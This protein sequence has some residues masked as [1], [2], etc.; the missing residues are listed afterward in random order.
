MFVKKT[1]LLIWLFIVCVS[2]FIFFVNKHHYLQ[3]YDQQYWQERYDQSQWQLPLSK[4]IIGDDGLYLFVG[5]RLIHK[6]DP[7][8]LNPETPPLGKYLIG[9]STV[10]FNNGAI[11]SLFIYFLVLATFYWLINNIWAKKTKYRWRNLL[12][13]I[14]L[15]AFDPLIVQQASQTA[16]D[17]PQLLLLLTYLGLLVR[18]EKKRPKV[19]LFIT[20]AL[21]GIVLG[22]FSATKLP[23]ISP[24]LVLT[25]LVYLYKI[26][27]LPYFVNFILFALTAYLISYLGYFLS[28]HTLLDWL[29][30]QKWVLNFY[31]TSQVGTNFGSAFTFFISG[32]YRSLFETNWLTAETWTA[33]WPIIFLVCS[34]F[35]IKNRRQLSLM[36]GANKIIVIFAYVI[37]L[38]FC[39]LPFF[40]RYLTLVIPFFYLILADLLLSNAKQKLVTPILIFLL[41]LNAYSS[42]KIL[43][44]TPKSTFEQIAYEWENA[45]FADL[46]E[47]T[48]AKNRQ[49][50][51][52]ADFN[53]LGQKLYYDLE[54]ESAKVKTTGSNWSRWD[55]QQTVELEVTYYTRNLGPFSEKKQVL[56]QKENGSWAIKWSWPLLFNL[57]DENIYIAKSIKAAK[58]G[59][60]INSAGQALA[61]DTANTLIWVIPNQIKPEQEA[62]MNN[63]LEALFQKRLYAV[64]IHNRIHSNSQP[65]WP[66]P[67]GSPPVFVSNTIRNELGHFSG[68]VLTP[69]SSRIALSSAGQTANSYFPECCSLLYST[70]NYDGVSGAEKEYNNILKGKN[71][72]YIRFV[73]PEGNVVRSVIE[74]EKSDG[75]DVYLP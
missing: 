37:L 32:R 71:G 24:F 7:S 10:I 22:L 47:H 3:P 64:E 9:L 11:I 72:G 73:D 14:G 66:I 31:Q 45:F 23:I 42:I 27:K 54:I 35:L 41:I 12:L 21:L 58:R 51:S 28:H 25:S 8:R 69:T 67:I 36:A 13:V 74:V 60:I 68:I 70:T 46:Y 6:A 18:I 2:I 63:Y 48:D 30:F 65:D 16:L 34:I 38:I 29:K 50:I 15:L 26:K 40:P 55:N 43:F 1:N 4:R 53:R 57:W 33:S 75:Q 5:N 61:F 20:T 19:N 62:A 44:P 59:K 17:L 39:L 56:I 49:G 52:R